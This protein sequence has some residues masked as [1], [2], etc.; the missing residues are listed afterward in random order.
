MSDKF[1]KMSIYDVDWKTVNND[2]EETVFSFKPLPFKHYPKIY[3][4]LG[5]LQ[6]L[7]LDGD[8][9]LSEEDKSKKFLSSVSEDVIDELMSIE[10]IMVK[11]SYPDLTDE[12]AELFVTSNLFQLVEPL[13][14]LMGRAEKFDKRRVEAV[15]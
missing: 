9:G 1:D 8:E 14:Q 15:R 6:D 10:L 11:N 3:K 2:G 5:R 12:K 13:V 7:N 4:V